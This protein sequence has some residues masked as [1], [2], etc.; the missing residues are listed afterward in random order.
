[1]PSFIIRIFNREIKII[2]K[3]EIKGIIKT[4]EE[5]IKTGIIN[6]KIFK[7]KETLVKKLILKTM[8]IISHP[9]VKINKMNS[10]MTKKKR[11][12]NKFD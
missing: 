12:H 8:I 7:I 1:M 3:I 10:K 11:A 2:T 9:W 4:I 5:E 6:S